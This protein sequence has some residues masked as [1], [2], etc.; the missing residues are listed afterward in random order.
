MR[1]SVMQ[2]DLQ[3]S[4][5]NLQIKQ[6]KHDLNAHRDLYHAL[7]PKKITHYTLHFAKYQGQLLEALKSDSKDDF[8]KVVVDSA[9]III[10]SS[11]AMNIDLEEVLPNKRPPGQFEDIK[12]AI[13]GYII[14]VSKM[15]KACEVLD[16]L[17][18]YPS[19]EILEDKIC[20]LFF[21]VDFMAS[22]S[23]VDLVQ[24]IEGRWR[25]IEEN[26][27]AYNH[28]FKKEIK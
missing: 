28:I 8:R 4:I 9:I 1:T 11:N 5:K 3:K 20:D 10:A 12:D 27:F 21:C 26:N 2:S 16:H 25:L 19:R 23:E 15:A 6:I 24:D 18:P 7:L 14:A 22:C 17:E 13:Q